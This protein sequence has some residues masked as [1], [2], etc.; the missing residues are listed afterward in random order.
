MSEND[1][2]DLGPLNNFV[3]KNKSGY[4]KTDDDL[5]KECADIQRK[6]DELSSFMSQRSDKIKSS[7]SDEI[8]DIKRQHDKSKEKANRIEKIKK[9]LADVQVKRKQELADVTK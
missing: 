6:C 2:T 5:T 4:S 8:A 1:F 7:C 3:E 9:I